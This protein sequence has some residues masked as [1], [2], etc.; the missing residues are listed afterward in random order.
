MGPSERE[1]R[2][3]DARDAARDLVDRY[4]EQLLQDEPLLGTMVGDE[5]YDDRLSDPSE[6]GRAARETLH[7]S[8]L[9]ELA[10]LERDLDDE[11]LRTTLDV[12]EAIA[13]RELAGLE[14]RVDRLSA[15]SHLWGPAALIGELASMQ[16]ADTPERVD[17]YVARLSATPAFYEAVVDVMRDGV[18]AGVTAPR[19]VVERSVAQVERLLA[20]PLEGSPALVP[21]S[22]EDEAGRTRVVEA[23]RDH[24]MPALARYLEALRG[25]LPAATETIGLSALPG[26]DEIYAAQILSWTSLP[27]EADAVH[28][29]GVADLRKIQD[30]R[31]AS[32]ERIGAPDAA[33]A[34]ALLDER[35]NRATSREQLVA[36]AERQ[37]QRGWD[38]APAWFGTMPS[39]NC[40]VKPVEEFRE[41]D[42]PFAFYQ[43]PSADGSR[44]GI[45][46]VNAGDLEGKPLHHHATTTYHEA[47]PGHHFQIA[48]EQE[49]GER[50]ALRRFGG[51]MAGSAFAEGWG[52][53]SERL[54]D[55]MELFEDEAE[56]LG[57]LE[58]QGMRAARLV[59]DT[60]IHAFGWSRERAIELLESAGVARVDAVIETDRYITL[61]GQALTYK[62]G[63]FEIEQQRA[64][65]AE[66]DGDAFSLPGFHDRLLSLGSL[67]LSALRRELAR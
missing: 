18:E 40:E 37:V 10:L 5:R 35:G 9:E 43:P 13:A 30:E 1:A 8:A 29:L 25:Y 63:Q 52:L 36:L 4:W 33:G 31:R 56:H 38:T 50:P 46:Y 3:S 58:M 42:M 45:Y 12:L 14:H 28:D 59:V 19:V 44:K 49:M 67:P 26:G 32:A 55:E 21:L 48:L 61:P 27:L 6:A 39:E 66:R 51:L 11:A 53:Y 23:L 64:A 15:V 60:G 47:N 7:R 57:M 20:T 34:V 16:R 2:L 54:A 65:A 17:R 62:I 22:Q 41:A 24:F